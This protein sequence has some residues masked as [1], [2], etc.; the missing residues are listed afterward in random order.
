MTARIIYNKNRFP[1]QIAKNKCRGC[2]GDVPKG[3]RTWCSDVCFQTYEPANVRFAC[4]KRDQGICSHCGIDTKKVASK[5]SRALRWTVPEH[6]RFFKKG[7]YDREKHQAAVKI[8]ERHRR[9]WYAA[10]E[11]RRATLKAEGWP[12]SSR[13]LW[14]M[15]HVIP[16]SEGGLTVLENV[17]TLC[18]PCHKKRTKKWHRERKQNLLRQCQEAKFDYEG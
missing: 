12:G 5:L 11:K 10:A 7:V 13:S 17:R 2:H 18:L 14:E 6:H 16:Y 15:D 3:R 9:R 4:L 8:A 1:K